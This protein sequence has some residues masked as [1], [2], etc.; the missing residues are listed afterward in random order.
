MAQVSEMQSR[1][2]W[3]RLRDPLVLIPVLGLLCADLVLASN[4]LLSIAAGDFFALLLGTPLLT[5]YSL[6][7]L[8]LW[9]RPPVG[10]IM[11]TVVSAVSLFIFVG[12]GN[13]LPTLAGPADTQAFLF[14]ISFPPALITVL[15]YSLLGLRAQRHPPDTGKLAQTVP[16]YTIASLLILGFVMGGIAVGLM[17]GATQSRLLANSSPADITIVQNAALPSTAQPY[18]PATFQAYVGQTVTWVN[19][20]TTAHTVTS[21]DNLFDSGIM[22]I[23]ARYE[24]T[25]T[26]AG[27]FQY[28]C[29]LHPKMIAEVIVS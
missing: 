22:A 6:S 8:A 16:R 23:G 13:P 28:Y 26:Q 25:F 17:A 29:T 12:V 20:D 19:R 7:L 4:V 14:A 9:R 27:T 3:S 5:L 10:Y 11:S 1:S 21:K 15:V 24:F 2:R 18:S